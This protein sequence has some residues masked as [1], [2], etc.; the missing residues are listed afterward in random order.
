MKTNKELEQ[1]FSE[2]ISSVASKYKF[3]ETN[4]LYEDI[5]KGPEALL[6]EIAAINLDDEKEPEALLKEIAVIDL[7]DVYKDNELTYNDKSLTNSQTNNRCYID[8]YK[9]DIDMKIK[10][11]QNTYYK[12]LKIA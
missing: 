4:A 7:N 1:T 8:N 11:S 12:S 2:M 9:K 10:L 6:K 5:K 3:D